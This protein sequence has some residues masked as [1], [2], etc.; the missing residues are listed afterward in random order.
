MS[1]KFNVPKAL[2]LLAVSSSLLMIGCGANTEKMTDKATE[3]MESTADKAVDK[4]QAMVKDAMHE[5]MVKE[6]S[7]VSE[8]FK[9][10]GLAKSIET[11]ASD[12]FEGRAPN[13]I[14]EEKTIAYIANEL[15]TAGFEPAVDGSYYQKV[16]LVSITP[17]TGSYMSFTTGETKKDLTLADNMTLWTKRVSEAESIKDSPLV[18][19]GYGVVAPEYDW[20]DY[21]GVDMK[22]KTAVILVN[23]PGFAT[24]DAD[25]FTGNSMT[26][27]GRWTYKY[28]EAARQGAAGAIIV[29]ETAPAGY[30]WE[31]VSGSWH[32]LVMRALVILS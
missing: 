6:P 32:C 11:L 14:G 2:T 22:G 18:F 12:A 1:L 10:D 27:Y 4:A 3:K 23:D 5:K 16:P 21:A 17:K 8:T 20:N 29:H 9:R 30:P 26:Y 25:L 28:E 7:Y 24:Q 15:K 13:S 19:V 31:V